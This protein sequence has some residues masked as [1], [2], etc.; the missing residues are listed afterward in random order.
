MIRSVDKHNVFLTTPDS[1]VGMCQRS[2]KN[3]DR[4]A[5]HQAIVGGEEVR[6]L[7]VA[8]GHGGQDV[9][10]R[11]SHAL[12]SMVDDANGDGSAA[13][14]CKAITGR[15]ERLT[16]EAAEGSNAGS[17]LTVVVINTAREELSVVHVG[18][19][20]ALL[21]EPDSDSCLSFEHRL[22]DSEEERM[23]VL[24]VGGVCIGQAVSSEGRMGGPLRAWPGGLAVCRTIGDA[25]CPG[26][27]A[28]PSTRCVRFDTR[29]G[30][31]VVVASDGVWDALSHERVAKL[32][33]KS[34]TASE[35]AELIVA[36]SIKARGLRDDTSCVVA[37]LGLPPWDES[38]FNEPSGVAS[39]MGRRISLAF[40][41]SRTPSS[42]PPS[43]PSVSPHCSEL[44]LF[45]MASSDGPLQFGSLQLSDDSSN[46][47]SVHSGMSEAVVAAAALGGGAHSP[48]GA[49]PSVTTFT[50]RV[51]SEDEVPPY[52]RHLTH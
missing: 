18:D 49:S 44:D 29:I 13:S 17:T 12:S 50:V 7:M 37:W 22:N 5:Q 26:A 42:S 43:S 52:P 36:K 34:R 19:S 16:K 27:S 31:A 45:Q 46:A 8:D 33:R 2:L 51:P 30:A 11:C 48:S 41:G 40:G 3:E 38:Y 15:F 9:A 25:D 28:V 32:V 10:E 14:M 24:A 6:L 23:R 39:R 21:V 4:M 20:A 47:S 35:A 1:S